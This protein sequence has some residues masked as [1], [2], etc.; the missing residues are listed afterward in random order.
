MKISSRKL[1]QKLMSFIFIIGFIGVIV[2]PFYWQVITSLKTPADISKIPTDLWPV[3]FSFEFYRN[4][5]V[6]YKF[7]VYL[8]NSIIVGTVTMFISIL[9]A[10]PAA[11]AFVRIDFKYKK[12]WRNFLLVANMFP[13]IAMVSPLF[14]FL[15]NII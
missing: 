1:L 13:I 8:K 9:L 10:V 5:F 7:G 4:V 11:Y 12:F 15:K 2:F 14:M 3:K 6:H